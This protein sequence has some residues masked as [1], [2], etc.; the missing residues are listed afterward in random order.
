MNYRYDEISFP[1][2]DGV[3]RIYGEIYSPVSAP[4]AVIQLTH[5]MIDHTGR[6]KHMAQRM[7]DAG[8]V[9]A[10][11]HHPGHGKSVSNDEDYGFFAERG[12]VQLL[13][14]DTHKMNRLLRERYPE[15]PIILLGHSMGSFVARL[16]VRQHPECVDGAIFHGT[17]GANPLLPLGKALTALV[18]LFR[19]SRHRSRLVT[20]LAFG[21]Y[22]KRFPKEEGIFAWLSSDTAMVK[23]KHD[24]PSTSFIFTAAAYMDLFRMLGE[25]NSRRW[26]REYPKSCPTLI[27]SGD[28]DPVGAYGKGPRQ[29]YKR[30]ALSG[31]NALSIRIYSGARHELF[32]EVCREEVFEDI[33]RWVGEVTR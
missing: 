7:C 29:V 1:S 25:C 18:R 26:Y 17:G 20:G 30:L 11:H 4:C 31:Q 12:G 33:I 6:Y 22:N 10:G 23:D 19:G 8:F 27:V 3:H 32:N 15:L 5:G 9:F 13:L 2:S 16:Y 28:M 14:D 24:D 21:A